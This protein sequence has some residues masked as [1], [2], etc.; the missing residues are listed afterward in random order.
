MLQVPVSLGLVYVKKSYR[1]DARK[2][3][4]L[5]VRKSYRLD[6]LL[7]ESH[8]LFSGMCVVAV[9]GKS[10]RLELLLRE[11]HMFFSAMCLKVVQA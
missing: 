5:D 7:R 8:L 4:K 2:S 1:L 9:K 10:Y 11:S 6:V 3:C